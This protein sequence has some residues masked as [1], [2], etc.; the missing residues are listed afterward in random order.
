M[1]WVKIVKFGDFYASANLVRLDALCFSAVIASVRVSW[2]L[3][4]RYLK[5][6]WTYFRQTSR[7]SAF[8]DKDERFTFWDRSSKS[9]WVQHVGSCM[10]VNATC[11]NFESLWTEFQTFSVDAFWTGMNASILRIKGQS[12]RSWKKKQKNDTARFV[13]TYFTYYYY[14]SNTV[15]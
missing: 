12:S 6:C 3:L 1:G 4:T 14:Q 13:D 10:F 8:W 7:C 2:T 11:W 9:D 15:L 5:K